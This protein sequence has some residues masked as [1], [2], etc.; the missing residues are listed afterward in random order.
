M[1]DVNEITEYADGVLW[2]TREGTLL[3]I[4]ITE[5][6]LDLAGTIQEIEFPELGDEYAGGDWIGEIQGKNVDVEIV[7]PLS[8]RIDEINEEVRDQ[9]SLLDDDP[10]GDAWILRA[11]ILS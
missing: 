8:L 9:F 2:F 10:T 7:A 4:G 11:T 3:T 6:A 1:S 5:K